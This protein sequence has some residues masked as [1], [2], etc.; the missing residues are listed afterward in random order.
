MSVVNS[1]PAASDWVLV[2]VVKRVD[3]KKVSEFLN[4]TSKYAHRN[5]ASVH[6]T[7]SAHIVQ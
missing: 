1:Y 3:Y 6:H 2:T 5:A 4:L 7:R